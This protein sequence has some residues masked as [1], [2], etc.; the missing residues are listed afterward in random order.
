MTETKVQALEHTMVVRVSL[1]ILE[2]VV[3]EN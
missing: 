2:T 3:T 1:N